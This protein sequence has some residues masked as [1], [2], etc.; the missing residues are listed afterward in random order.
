MKRQPNG[1]RPNI[2]SPRAITHLPVGGCATNAPVSESG[3]TDGSARICG[4]VTLRS[5]QVPS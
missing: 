3:T 2:H 5:G 4:S 1:V